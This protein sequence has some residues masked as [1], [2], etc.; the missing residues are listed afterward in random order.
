MK[1]SAFAVVLLFVSSMLG[2]SRPAPIINTFH[3]NSTFADASSLGS[4]SQ[5]F[6]HT[7]RSSSP[8]GTTATF[9]S[10]DTF[11]T[12][13]DGFTDTFAFGQIPSDSLRGDSSKHISLSVDTSQVDSFF[14]STCTCSFSTF[15]V[16]CQSGPFG[17]VQLDWQQNG[18]F[19]AS[20]VS[21]NKFAFFQFT[22]RTQVNAD[23]NSADVTGSVLGIP[24][25]NGQGGVG[26]NHDSTV[27][28]LNAR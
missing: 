2:Q 9:L 28:I 15:N 4:G 6:L 5:V 19:S 17:L 27:T 26:V 8:G 18:Q 23:G 14:T 25:S 22:Q 21:D 16:T 7:S 10:F 1:L 12:T 3:S 13:A 24:V 20:T 11:T